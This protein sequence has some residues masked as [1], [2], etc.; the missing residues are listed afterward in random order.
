LEKY[1]Q[2]G[3]IYFMYFSYKKK[4]YC[5]FVHHIVLG[6]SG[7]FLDFQPDEIIKVCNEDVGLKSYLTE[8]KRRRRK[9]KLNYYLRGSF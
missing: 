5:C 2:S 1:E 6:D 9:K 8:M 3:G 7:L 4:V